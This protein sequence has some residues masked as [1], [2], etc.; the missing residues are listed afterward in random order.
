MASDNGYNDP[1]LMGNKCSITP[2]VLQLP[3][4]RVFPG[5]HKEEGIQVESTRLPETRE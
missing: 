1:L 3:V 4:M 5:Y 2:P